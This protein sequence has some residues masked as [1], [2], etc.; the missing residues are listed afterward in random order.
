VD[1]NGNGDL[2]EEGKRFTSTDSA[3]SN[4]PDYPFAEIRHFP[5]ID[6][7]PVPGA[8]RYTR[9]RV[10]H[11]P[12][13][14]DFTPADRGNRELKARFEQ[15]PTFTRA[16]VT[17]YLDGKVRVQAVCEWADR[18]EGA[19]VCHIDGPLTMAP[20]RL[21]DLPRGPEPTELQFGLGSRGLGRGDDDA[22]ALLDYNL[23]PKEVE[24][25][26]EFRFANRNPEGPPITVEVKLKRC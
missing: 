12:I 5:T 6:H 2:T 16:G 13:K 7:L 10:T 26:A 19:P 17:L 14:K 20:V 23:V 9:F 4:R 3:G 25:V 24:P 1:R 15:D 21:Q 11:T 8:R 22:F 18:P